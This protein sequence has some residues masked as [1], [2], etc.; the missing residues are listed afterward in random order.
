[1]AKYLLKEDWNQMKNLT[2]PD[3]L[4][5]LRQLRANMSRSD[6]DCLKFEPDDVVSS[7]V[8]ASLNSKEWKLA[9]SKCYFYAKHSASGVNFLKSNI[10]TAYICKTFRIA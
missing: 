8:F 2:Q 4:T 10:V 5:D 3:L 9:R 1:M 7:F 6:L